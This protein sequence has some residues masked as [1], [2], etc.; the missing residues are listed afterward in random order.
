MPAKPTTIDEYLAALGPEQRAALEK[1]RKVIRS[2][3][4]KA[5]EYIGYGLAAFRLDG[6][7]VAGMGA[8]ASHC[9]Y[10]PM[11]GSVVATLKD[12]L[13]N[14]ETSKGAVRFSAKKPLPAALVRKLIQARI[15]EIGVP[16]T[17][18]R[19]RSRSSAK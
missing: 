14:Y 11:S 18:A 10:Y 17:P 4:P 19:T 2:V 8:G 12:E 7:P 5:E 15:A 1:L 9:A 6:Q 16:A 3:V 13:Q